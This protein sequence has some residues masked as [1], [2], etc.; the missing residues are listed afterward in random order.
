MNTQQKESQFYQ[1]KLSD[2][3]LVSHYMMAAINIHCCRWVFVDITHW[4]MNDNC[5]ANT[6]RIYQWRSKVG[7]IQPMKTSSLLYNMDYTHIH[8][9]QHFGKNFD[10]IGISIPYWK[11]F[12][13]H[14]KHAVWPC[15]CFYG[16][17]FLSYFNTTQPLL[18]PAS[19]EA[20]PC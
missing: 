13:I 18:I 15:M 7:L 5:G 11:S 20:S 14:R 4:S 10:L 17:G 12:Q 3:I 19:A 8:S 16:C 2:G 9:P 6:S 1:L